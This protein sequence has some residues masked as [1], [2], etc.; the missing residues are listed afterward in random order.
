MALARRLLPIGLLLVCP[1]AEAA[2]LY[3]QHKDVTQSRYYTGTEGSARAEPIPNSWWIMENSD[4]AEDL[5]IRDQGFVIEDEELSRLVYDIA[6]RLLAHWPGTTP[7]MAIF[8]QGDRSPL[9]YG[10][11]TT[12]YG[13]VFINYGVFRHAES[14][15]ELAAVIG[16]ELAHVLLGHGETLKYK[17]NVT[18]SLEV[19]SEARELYAKAEALRYNEARDEFSLDPSVEGEIKQSAVQKVIADRFYESA[20]ATLFSRGNERDADR[21]ALD[22]MVAAGYSPMGLKISL[23]RM[24]HSHDLSTAI[25]EY[26]SKSS[27]SLLQESLT[28]ISNALDQDKVD[29]TDL[30]RFVDN[31][32]GEFLD[33]ALNFGKRAAIDF[34]AK[35]HPVPSERVKQ[36]TEYLYD[37]YPRKV[38]RRRPDTV[39]AEHFRRGHIRDLIDRYTVANQAVEAIGV[40]APAIG[41]ELSVASLTPPTGAHPYTRYA[42]FVVGRAQGDRQAMLANAESIDPDMIMPVFASAE[43]ADFLSS[44]GRVQEANDIMSLYEGY[45]GT[46][47]DYYPPKIRMS[48]SAFELD[49]AQRLTDECFAAAPPDSPLSRKCARESGILRPAAG[50]NEGSKNAADT[51]GS[52]LKGITE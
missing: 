23:E 18:K 6:N 31:A 40:G 32:S 16:H 10:G 14:E 15:D 17:K 5:G 29:P 39:A 44:A 4:S 43:I 51:L 8:V 20:H 21:L 34:S 47:I 13:E 7:R 37:N 11:Q 38:R 33:S 9:S 1:G 26:L 50:P 25:S 19:F 28:A 45:Y 2:D 46:V 27:Q 42:A 35:S 36:I 30:D 12:Y 49:E 22:L 48:I 3:L 52:F 24:A 41:Q